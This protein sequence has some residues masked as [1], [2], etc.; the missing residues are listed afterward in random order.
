MAVLYLD[1]ITYLEKTFIILVF[2]WDFLFFVDLVWLGSLAFL[3][4]LSIPACSGA[5]LLCQLLGREGGEVFLLLLGGGTS[6]CLS[7]HV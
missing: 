4:T 5:A 3:L 6:V 1:E 7:Q 2:R